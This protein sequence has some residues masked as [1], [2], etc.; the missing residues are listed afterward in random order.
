MILHRF[1]AWLVGVLAGLAAAT[2]IGAQE[3]TLMW[4][5]TGGAAGTYFPLGGAI[6]NALSAPPGSTS[7][8]RGGSCGVPGLVVS[9]QATAGSVDNIGLLRN[10]RVD[11]A[12]VQADVIDAAFRGVDG[13]AKDGPF[14]DLRVIAN[15]YPEH[16]HLIARADS[17]IEAITD[18]VGKRVSLDVYGSG[19]HLVA[20][21]TLAAFGLQEVEAHE[22]TLPAGLAAERLE[23]G[24]LDAFMLMAGA[25]AAAARNLIES[26]VARLL[27]II[28]RPAGDVAAQS[29]FLYLSSIPGDAYGLDKDVPTIAVGS[30][31]VVR[32]DMDETLA[33]DI[34]RALF[35]PQV[36]SQLGRAHPMARFITLPSALKGVTIKLHP[37]AR[38]YY[39]EAGLTGKAIAAA[40]RGRPNR[41]RV[42]ASAMRYRIADRHGTGD[43]HPAQHPAAPIGGQGGFQPRMGLVHT[44]AGIGFVTHHQPHRADDDVS[45]DAARQA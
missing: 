29:G 30:Q 6:A 38:R 33:Y 20:E 8:E 4:I 17:G 9:A 41:G 37:G 25:P 42:R 34:T 18:L 21:R 32:A 11:A 24:Q 26:G 5:G 10:R 13:F 40:V 12:L 39:R 23:T 15:L 35:R 19:S 7:C 28:G 3:V 44:L 45:A 36:L 16:L 22:Q 14:D 27:P 1:R 31:L 43:R 2:P